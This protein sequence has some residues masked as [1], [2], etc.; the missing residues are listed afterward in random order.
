[1][2]IVINARDAMPDGGTLRIS[3]GEVT[4]T[5]A[6]FPSHPATRP[7][8]YVVLTIH[9][10]GIGMDEATQAR[11][12]EPFFTTKAIGKGTG[13]GLSAVYG[14]VTQ[15]GGFIN[16]DSVPGEGTTFQIYLPR[17]EQPTDSVLAPADRLIRPQGNETILLVDDE[18]RLRRIACLVLQGSGYTILEAES[19]DQALN[20]V[21]NY[22]GRIDLVLTDV[23][24][25]GMNGRVLVERLAP[26]LPHAKILYMTGYTDD[27]VLRT[28]VIDAA[29]SLLQ[30]PFTSLTLCQKVRQVLDGADNSLSA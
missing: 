9:D 12:F 2:N 23:V 27:V 1:M 14:I 11:I 3:T 7:G 6:D 17:I 18:A 26:R 24:L 19:G 28:G 22:V 29:V 13:M 20:L 15:Q 5:G 4:F 10:N 8:A 25:P 30:K 16:V 21:E